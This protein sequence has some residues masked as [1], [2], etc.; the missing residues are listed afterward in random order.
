MIADLAVE[1]L[2][3]GDVLALDGTAWLEITK[4]SIGCNR[5]EAAQ[6]KNKLANIEVGMLA[7]VIQ[8]GLIQ[9]GDAVCLRPRSSLS[10][11]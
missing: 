3:P 10:R 7:G 8:S 4:P 6:G 11:L 5:L 1:T 9:A 2:E